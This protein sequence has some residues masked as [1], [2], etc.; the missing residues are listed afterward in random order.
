[1][2]ALISIVLSS[3]VLELNGKKFIVLN[4]F[5]IFFLDIYLSKALFNQPMNSI[6]YGSI[7]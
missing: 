7:Y 1:M 3:I 6:L 5:L 4:S 2:Y